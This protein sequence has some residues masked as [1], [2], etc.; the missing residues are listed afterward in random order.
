MA[1]N[2]GAWLVAI[3]PIAF[4][5]GW[6]LRPVRVWPIWIAA[7]LV[8]WAGNALIATF[9]LV[10]EVP[11]AGEETVVSFMIESTLGLAGLVLLPAW[12]GRSVS[13]LV[14][15]RVPREPVT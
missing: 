2:S 1:L 3:A 15:H 4:A 11:G 9:D 6:L 5:Y 13:R 14:T 12:L 7:L 10:D 8:L